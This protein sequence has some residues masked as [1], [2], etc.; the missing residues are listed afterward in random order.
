MDQMLYDRMVR[1]RL[2]GVLPD[3]FS[4]AEIAQRYGLD[5]VV[6]V[7]TIARLAHDGLVARK[8]GYG[9]RFL[10]TLDNRSALRGSYEFRSAI[11][12]A[13]ILFRS[14][15]IDGGVLDKIRMQH[16]RLE[17]SPNFGTIDGSEFFEIDAAFHEMIADF[18]GNLFVLHAVQQQNRLR[19]LFEFGTYN[20]RKRVR[21]WLRE[22]LDIMEALVALDF[23][24]ASTLMED[25]IANARSKA[26]V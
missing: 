13:A 4:Q 9:W 22:H 5:R 17:A 3:S 16:I 6:V 18:S 1:D 19:R 2:E 21:E 7:R 14:F 8:K 10:P 25:H 26:L 15:R 24:R 23:T 11:E 12:P 20:N